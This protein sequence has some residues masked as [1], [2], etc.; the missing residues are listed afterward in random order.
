MEC[1]KRNNTFPRE[2]LRRLASS[3]EPF[4]NQIFQRFTTEGKYHST[5]YLKED[6]DRFVAVVS[7][8]DSMAKSKGINFLVVLEDAGK[9]D[10][11]CGTKVPFAQE[12]ASRLSQQR[13]N[14]I[15][16]SGV[17]TKEICKTTKLTV[18]EYDPHPSMIANKLL[19]EYF[20]NNKLIR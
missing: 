9:Y 10:E 2:I 15:L 11:L 5:N 18:S 3:S 7:R 19:S 17:Y 13:F 14:L 6:V 20:I 1:G 16:T 4:T 8:M 12:L